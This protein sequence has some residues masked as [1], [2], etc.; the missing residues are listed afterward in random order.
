MVGLVRRQPRLSSRPA[1]PVTPTGAPARR[2]ADVIG[3]SGTLADEA[4]AAQTRTAETRT[5]PETRTWAR[6]QHSAV[7]VI[8]LYTEAGEMPQPKT[9]SRT[10]R[11]CF[12]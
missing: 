7:T 2:P 10:G 9:D 1:P 5:G 3:V 6:A 11:S 12:R 8:T 4:A